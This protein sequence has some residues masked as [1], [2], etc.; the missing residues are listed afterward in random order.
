MIQDSM[1]VP[2]P[3][4]RTKIPSL[5]PL[6]LGKPLLISGTIFNNNLSSAESNLERMTRYWPLVFSDTVAYSMMQVNIMY[7]NVL[8]MLNVYK[9]INVLCMV[10]GAVITNRNW[11]HFWASFITLYCQMQNWTRAKR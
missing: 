11:S 7:I 1:L 10:N 2:C 8:C 3:V 4:E 6:Q 5:Y 9:C